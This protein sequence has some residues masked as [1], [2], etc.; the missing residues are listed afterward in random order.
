M[1]LKDKV[2]IVTGAGTGLGRAISQRYGEEGASIVAVDLAGHAETVKAI[3]AAGGK[4]IAVRAD[5][6]AVNQVESTVAACV[7]AF[8]R[9]DILVNN[10][11]MSACLKQQAFE[12]IDIDQ[13][14]RVMDV[15]VLR[16]SSAFGPSHHTCAHNGAEALST[17]GPR[18]R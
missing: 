12:D 17:W 8:G 9:V 1:R 15:N 2:A 18:R 13:W 10:A 16:R 14:R 5:V 4:A 6:S 11:A 3:V 7:E